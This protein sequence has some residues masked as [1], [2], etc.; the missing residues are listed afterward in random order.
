MLRFIWL[1]GVLEANQNYKE[2]KPCNSAYYQILILLFHLNTFLFEREFFF[3]RYLGS[4]RASV[5]FKMANAVTFWDIIVHVSYLLHAKVFKVVQVISNIY[6]QGEIIISLYLIFL[7][8]ACHSL[9][10]RVALLF[11]IIFFIVMA[12][13]F[14]GYFD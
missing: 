1:L 14:M 12:I 9:A 13:S 11:T 5:N 3:V 2:R 8:K 7:N 6:T 10:T 4:L